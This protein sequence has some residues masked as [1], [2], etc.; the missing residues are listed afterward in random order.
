LFNL[1]LLTTSILVSPFTD[2][3]QR[4]SDDDLS[5]IRTNIESKEAKLNLSYKEVER[6]LVDFD[7]VCQFKSA[8]VLDGSSFNLYVTKDKRFNYIRVLNGFDGT[9]QLYGPFTKYANK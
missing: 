9:Y 7:E 6:Y 8:D 3:S 1:F 2:S 4:C 5:F